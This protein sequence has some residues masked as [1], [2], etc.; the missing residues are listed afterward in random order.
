[1][2][3]TSLNLRNGNEQNARSAFLKSHKNGERLSLMV[4]EEL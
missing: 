3:V 1:V 4:G 2:I